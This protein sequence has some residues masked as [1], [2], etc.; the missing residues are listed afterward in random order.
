MSIREGR[1]P[2]SSS[3]ES[4]M[5]V[6]LS[7]YRIEG[8]FDAGGCGT[9]LVGS[10]A[11]SKQPVVM[12]MA[13]KEVDRLLL[14]TE[15]RIYARLQKARGWPRLIDAGTYRKRDVLVLERLGP[16]L[17]DLL[18]L[19][20]GRFGLKTVSQ[21]ALQLL[22]RLETFHELGYVH[23][24]LKPDNVLL[25][26]GTTRKTLHLIDFGLAE[27]YRH[28]RTG[29]HIAQDAFFPFAGTIEFAPVFAHLEYT[30]SRRDDIL[31]LAYML[32][33]LLRGGLPWYGTEERFDPD[34]A[35]LLKLCITPSELCRGLPA[36]FQRL[37]EYA[38]RMEFCDAPDYTELKRMFRNLL[39]QHSMQHDLHFD[40]NR[41]GC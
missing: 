9:V 34:E 10:H 20:G 30:P 6:N 32:V 26:R 4:L 5:V 25:G 7:T 16:S 41:F 28:P 3:P 13:S 33:F 18:N 31:S 11:R 2:N 14:A 29:E 21:L 17:Q 38:L 12:K 15:R 39:R 8:E 27:P 22:D 1:A 40:W 35:L 23:R 36:E 24:D 19:C 37:T